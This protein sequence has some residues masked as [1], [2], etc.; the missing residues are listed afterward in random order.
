MWINL[1]WFLRVISAALQAQRASMKLDWTIMFSLM[2]M[3]C[4]FRAEFVKIEAANVRYMRWFSAD[5]QI[6]STSTTFLA[7]LLKFA[8][9]SAVI[10]IEW[11]KLDELS[12]IS[13]YAIYLISLILKA[14]QRYWIY[15]K[16]SISFKVHMNI[17]YIWLKWKVCVPCILL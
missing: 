2:K 4:I 1:R 11:T 9:Y 3:L 5:F 7:N 6:C 16:K 8:A 10:D 13:K 15:L 12:F 17:V 14:I